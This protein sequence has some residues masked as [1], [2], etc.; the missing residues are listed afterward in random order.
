MT[1][2]NEFQQNRLG[3]VVGVMTLQRDVR[4]ERLQKSNSFITA[5]LSRLC[6]KIR[7]R[8]GLLGSANVKL[9]VESRTQRLD[10]HGVFG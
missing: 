6:L 4:A 7:Q 1:P 9:D 3:L 10:K 8:E 5:P 2:A